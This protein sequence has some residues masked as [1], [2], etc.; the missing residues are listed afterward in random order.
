VGCSVV[1]MTECD[2]DI[3]AAN[4]AWRFK[5]V[6][7]DGAYVRVGLELSSRHLYTVPCNSIVEVSERCVNNQGLARL[8]TADGWISEML[9]P[10]SGQVSTNAK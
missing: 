3:A 7:E 1:R 8:R 4:A 2:A 6:C 9:N 10:L 5:V